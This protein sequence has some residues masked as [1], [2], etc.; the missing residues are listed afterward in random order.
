[1]S[2]VRMRCQLDNLMSE[3]GI[4]EAFLNAYVQQSEEQPPPETE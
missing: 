1:M 2:M 4:Q 3:P